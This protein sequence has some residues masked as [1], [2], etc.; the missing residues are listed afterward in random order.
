M[1]G[2]RWNHLSSEDRQVVE[3]EIDLKRE[4]V[5]A[6]V[7]DTAHDARVATQIGGHPGRQIVVVSGIDCRREGIQAQVSA[8]AAS[9]VCRSR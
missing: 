3:E 9:A 5:G 1:R 2:N 4:L 8:A 7:H 6:H